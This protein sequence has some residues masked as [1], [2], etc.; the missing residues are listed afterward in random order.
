MLKSTV[1]V[2]AS[3]IVL[4]APSITKFPEVVTF[5]ATTFPWNTILPALLKSI[6][7]LVVS[8]VF[9]EILI[10]SKFI[11]PGCIVTAWTDKFR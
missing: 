11:C 3:P 9:P 10:L 8:M 1:S 7:D 5:G 2:G 4:M 6:F